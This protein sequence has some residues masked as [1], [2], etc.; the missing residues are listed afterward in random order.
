VL[1]PHEGELGRL[2]GR[3]SRQIAAHRL[4]SVREAAE[5]FGC[6]VLLKGPDTLVAETGRGLLV[7][8]LG[9]PSLATAGTGDVLT[10]IVAAFLAKGMEAQVAAAA[11]AAAQQLASV[12][13]TQRAG[14]VASDLLDALPR[15]LA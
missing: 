10:G 11:A 3:D 8:S 12:E 5:R 6:V 1:T 4:T 14:L 15:V 13:A 2:L 9:L 7:T